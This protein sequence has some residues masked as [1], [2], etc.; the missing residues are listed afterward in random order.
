MVDKNRNLVMA[1]IDNRLT[2]T[3]LAA[4]SGVNR[5]TIS[6]IVNNRWVPS[7]DQ[8]ERIAEALRRKPHELF[9]EVA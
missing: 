6:M 5:S 2:Q 9:R 3:D 4:R 1:L 8:A 7:K